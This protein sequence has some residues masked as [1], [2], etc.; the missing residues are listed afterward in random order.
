MAKDQILMAS[1]FLPEIVSLA[2]T[3]WD[4]KYIHAHKEAWEYLRSC[5]SLPLAIVIG[6]VT[7]TPPGQRPTWPEDDEQLPAH[8]ML[9]RI[10]DLDSDMPVIVSASEHHSG[11]IVELIKRG[12][13]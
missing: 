12:A 4:V 8:V 1:G 6:Y 5:D 11:A 2:R 13:F 10:H 7:R 3:H 9:R